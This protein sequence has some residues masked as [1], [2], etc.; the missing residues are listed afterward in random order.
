[1]SE[2]LNI[3]LDGSASGL[4]CEIVDSEANKRGFK[5]PSKYVQY[6][7]EKDIYKKRYAERQ[8]LFNVIMLCLVFSCLMLLLMLFMR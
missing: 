7:L 6:L 1:M 2:I 3:S 5:G 4:T 8:Y